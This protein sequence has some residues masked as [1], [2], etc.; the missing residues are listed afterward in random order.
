MSKGASD[1][2]GDT[3][4]VNRSAAPS[5]YPVTTAKTNAHVWIL[6]MG[7]FSSRRFEDGAF[8]PDP[9]DTLQVPAE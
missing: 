7:L 9:A 6:I 8:I 3:L 5:R 2:V 4:K 1:C